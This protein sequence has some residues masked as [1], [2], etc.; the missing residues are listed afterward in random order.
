[1]VDVGGELVATDPELIAVVP[2][3]RRGAGAGS[4]TARRVHAERC[5]SYREEGRRLKIAGEKKIWQDK[6]ARRATRPPRGRRDPG[7]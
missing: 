2:F 4:I 1:M 6:Q 7:L 5:D 3:E